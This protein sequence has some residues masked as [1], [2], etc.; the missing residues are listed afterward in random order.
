MTNNSPIQAHDK[1]GDVIA[2]VPP[3]ALARNTYTSENNTVSSVMSFSHDTTAIEIAAIGGSASMMW[4]TQG[5]TTASII[6]IAGA[7]SNFDHVIPSG[8]VRRF[9]IPQ[10]TAGL[11]SS[12]I[13]GINR[14]AG[15]YQRVA[16]KSFGIGS[17]MT[18]EY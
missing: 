7:T 10:E 13:V 3:P 4:V 17:V 9:I 8:T 12:S 2:N 18:S 16:I 15:L 1:G 11:G 5:D 14:Q 6:T